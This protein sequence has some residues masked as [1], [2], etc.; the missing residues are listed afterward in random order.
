MADNYKVERRNNESA[1]VVPWLVSV[2]T[3][4]DLARTTV[5]RCYT[6]ADAQMI[7][8]ALNAYEELKTALRNKIVDALTKS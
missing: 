5:C 6:K 1:P 8:T 2:L 4:G 7:A 3:E